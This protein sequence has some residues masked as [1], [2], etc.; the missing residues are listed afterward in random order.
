MGFFQRKQKLFRVTMDIC[1]RE[2]KTDERKVFEFG[3]QFFFSTERSAI[4]FTELV[5]KNTSNE[6]MVALEGQTFYFKLP[7]ESE[8]IYV[9]CSY[10]IAGLGEENENSK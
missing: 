3:R 2:I 9:D 1:Y 5:K 7:S 6:F 10:D 4:E 8:L